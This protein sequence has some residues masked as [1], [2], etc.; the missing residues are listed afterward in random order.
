MQAIISWLMAHQSVLYGAR[1]AL[2]DFLFAMVPSW[3]SNGL[4]HWLYLQLGGK[5]SA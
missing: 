2:L 5:D 4:L 3:K 1:V